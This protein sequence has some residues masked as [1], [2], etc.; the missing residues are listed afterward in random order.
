MAWAC[1]WAHRA[2]LLRALKGLEDAISVTVLGYFLEWPDD[3]R[4]Y[5]GWPFQ[6]ED[7][8]PLHPEFEYLHDVYKLAD[9][10]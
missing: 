6:K 5:R 3:G 7:P 10:E 1:P 4:P 8:D 9:P 2:L